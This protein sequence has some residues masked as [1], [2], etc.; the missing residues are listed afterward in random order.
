[1]P[2]APTTQDHSA[3]LIGDPHTYTSTVASPDI[4]G[5][6]FADTL[7]GLSGSN[8]ILYGGTGNDTLNAGATGIDILIGG[9][10]NNTLTGTASAS[11]TSH[12]E[13]VLQATQTPSTALEHDIINN[14]NGTFDGVLVDIGAGGTVAT[15]MASGGIAS[16]DIAS[17]AT[18]AAAFSSGT[19]HFGFNTA[20]HELY[21]SADA[22]A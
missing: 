4:I 9:P 19:N 13:F 21:Y 22:T 2:A 20:S 18:T 14:F 3:D 15:A 7:T 16:T 6:A 12:D 8:D 11:L 1:M 5:S 10:G 17:G